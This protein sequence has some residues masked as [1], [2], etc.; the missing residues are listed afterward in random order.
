MIPATTAVEVASRRPSSASSPTVLSTLTTVPSS[1]RIVCHAIV[2][3]R[4]VTKNGATTRTR[5]TFFHFPARK[6]IQ[7][8]SG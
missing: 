8:A 5:K 3:I 6:A 2:R 4:Y 7:Y 1:E